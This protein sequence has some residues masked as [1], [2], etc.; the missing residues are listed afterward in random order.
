MK[1]TTYCKNNTNPPRYPTLN[2]PNDIIIED[3]NNRQQQLDPNDSRAS[4]S[5]VHSNPAPVGH[6]TKLIDPTTV[7]RTPTYNKI[8]Q[9]DSTKQINNIKTKIVHPKFQKHPHF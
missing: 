8:K 6:S 3:N 2:S 7:N 9:S 1:V 5:M 4:F